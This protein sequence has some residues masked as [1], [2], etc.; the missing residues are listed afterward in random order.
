MFLFDLYNCFLLHSVLLLVQTLLFTSP[1]LKIKFR[2]LHRLKSNMQKYKQTN[3]NLT[4]R[5]T[6]CPKKRKTL[7]SSLY[8]CQFSTNILILVEN[9]LRYWLRNPVTFQCKNTVTAVMAS[10]S[11][12]ASDR[13]K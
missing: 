13:L 4:C 2:C 10:A 12:L 11:G 9:W 1:K 6:L 5:T 7:N 3:K 8:L